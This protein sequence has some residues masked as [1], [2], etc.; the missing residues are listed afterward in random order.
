MSF[1]EISCIKLC[2]TVFYWWGLFI[3]WLCL[4]LVGRR[5]LRKTILNIVCSHR[6]HLRLDNLRTLVL[7][8]NN[9]ARIQLST[10]D[11]GGSSISEEEETDWVSCILNFFVTVSKCLPHTLLSRSRKVVFLI[12]LL[13]WNVKYDCLASMKVTK[14][15]F[16][17]VLRNSSTSVEMDLFYW[18]V[19]SLELQLHLDT[20]SS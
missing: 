5:S 15:R 1:N 16:Y 17:M 11:D 20:L 18:L 4:W 6:R 10:D 14:G 12:L 2:K 13:L 9:L 19:I 7:A 8:D 3:L